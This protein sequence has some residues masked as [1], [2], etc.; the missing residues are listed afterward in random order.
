MSERERATHL[1]AVIDHVL[2]RRRDWIESDA[3]YVTE[4]VETAVDELVEVFSGG[5]IPGSCRAIEGQVSQLGRYWRDWKDQVA[6]TGLSTILPSNDFWKAIERV[7]ELREAAKPRPKRRL[8]TIQDLAVVQKVPAYQIC[9]IYGWMDENGQPESWKIAEELAEPGKHTGPESGWVD[10][11]EKKRLEGERKRAAIVA[12]LAAKQDAK[13]A[14]ANL[15]APESLEELVGTD[16]PLHQ[17]ADILKTTEAAVLAECDRLGL[18]RPA[19]LSSVHASRAPQE[20]GIAAEVEAGYD[21]TV[22]NARRVRAAEGPPVSLES[23]GATN[24]GGGHFGEGDV[25]FDLDSLGS[26][27]VE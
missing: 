5:T 15:K 13:I 6:A 20:P 14:R 16:V 1:L 12:R 17:I 21:A 7:A 8:E 11:G 2:A 3:P 22:E 10:P 9:D 19:S 23:L 4:D 27:E 24:E 26:E 18:D 25:D